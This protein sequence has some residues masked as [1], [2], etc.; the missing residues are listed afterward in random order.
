MENKLLATNNGKRNKESIFVCAVSEKKR[1][2][3][4]LGR[5]SHSPDWQGSSH[6]EDEGLLSVELG[7]LE[8]VVPLLLP[9]EDATT[10]Q[11]RLP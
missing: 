2:G 5:Q 9:A 6:L 1:G 11:Q 8:A 4:W 3:G 10:Q 7:D